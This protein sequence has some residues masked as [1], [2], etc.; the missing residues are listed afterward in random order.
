ML[1]YMPSCLTLRSNN[2]S[3]FILTVSP[4]CSGLVLQPAGKMAARR[5]APQPERP[6]RRR[7]HKRRWR[8]KPRGT[9]AD[10]GGN[11]GL[12]RHPRAHSHPRAARRPPAFQ[13][14]LQLHVPLHT[15]AHRHNGRL[16]Q[17]RNITT[18]CSMCTRQKNNFS[19]YLLY[20]T[21]VNTALLPPL[22]IPL[23]MSKDA[24]YTLSCL[25]S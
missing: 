24:G 23:C 8:R 5:E 14:R 7:R 22:Q 18:N 16:V 25:R 12:A 10:P 9:D 3:G 4:Q 11:A 1:S 13:L 21:S 17:V 6:W 15:S 20:C 19:H 2:T